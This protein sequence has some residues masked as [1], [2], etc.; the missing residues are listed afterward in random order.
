MNHCGTASGHR[1]KNPP[2]SNLKHLKTPNALFQISLQF[3]GELRGF[4]PRLPAYGMPV[5]F[6]FNF[7][8]QHRQ[9]L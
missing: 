4:I 6:S 5:N 7:E 9:E 3:P 2:G 8:Q 1:A